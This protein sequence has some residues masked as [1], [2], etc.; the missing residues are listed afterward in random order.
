M[1]MSLGILTP[2]SDKP[3]FWYF[4]Q[5]KM[6]LPSHFLYFLVESS[7]KGAISSQKIKTSNWRHDFACPGIFCMY[8]GESTFYIY[9]DIHTTVYLET[10]IPLFWTDL[11]DTILSH[12]KTNIA[13]Q[14]LQ[15]DSKISTHHIPYILKQDKT[16]AFNIPWNKTHKNMVESRE[17]GCRLRTPDMQSITCRPCLT[18]Q[19]ISSNHQKYRE[20]S[21]EC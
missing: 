21:P 14:I 9:N 12:W 17:P 4:W 19:A 5:Q 18:T 10:K 11:E 15:P 13:C 16:R 7:K 6:G 20:T 8:H 2:F 3:I 1:A